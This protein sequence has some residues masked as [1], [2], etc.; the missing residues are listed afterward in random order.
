VEGAEGGTSEASTGAKADPGTSPTPSA[1]RGN[2][3]KKIIGLIPI[4]YLQNYSFLYLIFL[5]PISFS[6]IFAKIFQKWNLL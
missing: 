3:Q 6:C 5:F 4:I 2:A 1:A